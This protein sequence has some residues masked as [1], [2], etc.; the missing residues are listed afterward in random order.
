MKA[1]I[2]IE[3]DTDEEMLRIAET[4]AEAVITKLE[5]DSYESIADCVAFAIS[6]YIQGL[7]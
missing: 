4:G 1:K 6:D 7:G 2:I 3:I 5:C